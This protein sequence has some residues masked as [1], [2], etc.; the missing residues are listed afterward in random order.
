[1]DANVP[2]NPLVPCQT[3]HAAVA[4][5]ASTNVDKALTEAVQHKQ[6][7]ADQFVWYFW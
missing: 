6:S 4:A 2:H 5:A 3:E 7:V 1:M